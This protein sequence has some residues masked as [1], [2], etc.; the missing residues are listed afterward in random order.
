MK[1]EN[2]YIGWTLLATVIGWISGMVLSVAIFR[3]INQARDHARRIK[4]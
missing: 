4:D 1:T 3:K 2:K